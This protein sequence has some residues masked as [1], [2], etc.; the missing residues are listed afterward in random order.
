ME[1]YL[2]IK[3]LTL[4]K[5]RFLLKTCMAL[6]LSLLLVNCD[7]DEDI[8]S[9]EIIIPETDQSELGKWIDSTFRVPYNIYVDY[10]WNSSDADPTR[11]LVPPKEHLVKPFLQTVLKIWIA[12]Y[13]TVSEQGNNFMK[14]YSCRR[15]KLIGSGS[16]NEGS[17]T[18][19]LAENGYKITLYTIN[20]FNLQTGISRETL[21]EY[22]RVMHHESGIFL[23]R[24]KPTMKIFRT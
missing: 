14:D 12:P 7:R 9:S 13:N 2:Y 15:L 3:E 4:R 19:G 10:R 5:L 11:N 20:D 22:F 1:T 17:V 18:L 8:T 21:R 6:F 23:T 16:Y 24:E